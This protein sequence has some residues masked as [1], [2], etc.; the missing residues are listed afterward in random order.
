M[1]TLFVQ[2]YSKTSYPPLCFHLGNGFSDTYDLC[3][4]KGDFHWVRYHYEKIVV[5][6]L[7]IKKGTV[8]ISSLF[9]GQLH[10]AYLWAKKYP[11]IKF[12]VG[13]PGVHSSYLVGEIPKNL[14]LTEKTVEEWFEVPNFSGKW[15]LQIPKEIPANDTIYF[16]YVL[17]NRCYWGNCIFCSYDNARTLTANR[18]RKDIK[19]EFEKINYNGKKM[20]RLGTDA[21]A[22][23][24]IRILNKLP[25]VKNLDSYKAFLRA[26]KKELNT[27][28]SLDNL[29]WLDIIRFNIGLEFPTDRMWK[30][31]K[32]GYDTETVV[33]LLNFL[34][35]NFIIKI[36]IGWNNLIED[37]LINL[38]RFMKRIPTG[39]NRC[40]VKLGNLYA[41]PGTYIHETYKKG[42]EYFLEPFYIGFKPYLTKDQIELN[43]TAKDIVLKYAEKKR[44]NILDPSKLEK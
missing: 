20:I 19:F 5:E 12:I 34:K 31:M 3:N 14:L 8:Y 27:I 35:K 2:F 17:D 40:T 1:D 42:K 26:G 36:I 13:G 22:P 33:E 41:I 11:N 43:N 30:Y 18:I 28:K 23:K 29:D 37:D 7:P 38:E 44:Y 32:K 9:V 39:E 6:E 25:L 24:H 15:N 10:I 21:I 16:T 4:R